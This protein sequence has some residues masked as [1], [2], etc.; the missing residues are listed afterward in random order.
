MRDL[1]KLFNR[2][3]SAVNATDN[4]TPSPS[5][6]ENLQHLQQIGFDQRH[7]KKSLQ[8]TMPLKQGL[9]IVDSFFNQR[10]GGKRYPK[11]KRMFVSLPVPHILVEF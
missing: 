5:A 6:E 2:R 10:K 8:A 4:A 11:C 7:R 1:L 3:Y 9:S